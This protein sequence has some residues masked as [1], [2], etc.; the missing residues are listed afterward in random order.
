MND[1]LAWIR[2]VLTGLLIEALYAGAIAAFS[3][4]LG[5]IIWELLK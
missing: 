1:T 4:S 3:L 5:V 2:Q